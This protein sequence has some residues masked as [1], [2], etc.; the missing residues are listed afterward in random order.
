MLED[1]DAEAEAKATN[2]MP[3]VGS[4]PQEAIM[5]QPDPGLQCNPP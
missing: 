1:A 2:G 5:L 3:V 4:W